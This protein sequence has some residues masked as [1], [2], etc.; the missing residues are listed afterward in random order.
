MTCELCILENKTNIYI[1][2]D[3]FI[4]M[5]CDSCFVPMIV[6]KDHTMSIPKSDINIMELRLT[7][8]A[9]MFYSDTPFFIDKKQRAVLEHLHWHAREVGAPLP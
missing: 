8:C 6:W 7:E 9:E 3:D 4:I 1:E 2:N 5:D